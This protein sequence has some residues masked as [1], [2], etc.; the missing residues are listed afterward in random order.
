MEFQFAL[1]LQETDSLGWILSSFEIMKEDGRVFFQISEYLTPET[2]KKY[3]A[4]HEKKI[5][6]LL[7]NC[8]ESAL[9]QRYNSN[10][11]EVATVKKLVH[12]KDE[13]KE[14]LFKIKERDKRLPDKDK[15]FDNIIRPYVEKNL[16]EAF[17][18]ARKHNVPIYN[19][20]VGANF[21]P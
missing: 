10:P 18:L 9:Y 19:K 3:L 7:A 2:N 6:D 12:K 11:K 21:Y 1:I 15:H 14:F 8:E 16:P 5:V 13:L 20:V 17:L 4:P